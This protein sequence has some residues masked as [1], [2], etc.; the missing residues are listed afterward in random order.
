MR[1][2]LLM[3][4]I[5]VPIDYLKAARTRRSVLFG[6]FHVSALELVNAPFPAVV[7]EPIRESINDLVTHHIPR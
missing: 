1:F 4:T 5:C 3:L 2:M 6:L 7:L